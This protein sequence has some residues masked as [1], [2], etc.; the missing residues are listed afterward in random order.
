MKETYKS[1][2]V[3]LSVIVVLYLCFFTAINVFIYGSVMQ[4]NMPIMILVLIFPLYVGFKRGE[5]FKRSALMMGAYVL[6]ILLATYWILPNYTFEEA[7]A[8]VV[9]DENPWILHL[10][11]STDDPG[12]FYSGNYLVQTKQGDFEVDLKNGGV[13]KLEVE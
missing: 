12:F 4:I 2:Y 6:M 13:I 1:I 7:K 3:L 8:M 5:Y 9:N 10:N 11:R